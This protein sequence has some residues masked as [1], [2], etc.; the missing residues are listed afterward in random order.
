[1]ALNG[2]QAQRW[3][4]QPKKVA[5][6]PRMSARRTEAVGK[7][8][9]E[10]DGILKTAMTFP[11]DWP[12]CC[13]P[14]GAPEAS[15]TI[16]RLV[17]NSPPVAADF[18]SVF[19]MEKQKRKPRVFPDDLQCQARGLSVY[20]TFVDAETHQGVYQNLGDYIASGGASMSGAT[21]SLGTTTRSTSASRRRWS[22]FGKLNTC[23][24]AWRSR[25]R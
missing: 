17:K 10:I 14:D 4:G 8:G 23:S 5:P 9:M 12:P 25:T 13:P 20:R 7:D 1:M 24:L 6:T 2:R 21:H 16:F 15:G 22:R 18:V 19:E 3:R 11:V